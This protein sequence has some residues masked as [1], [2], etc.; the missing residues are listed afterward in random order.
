MKVLDLP[1][2]RPRIGGRQFL[3][4][5]KKVQKIIGYLFEKEEQ[6]NQV[7]WLHPVKRKLLQFKKKLY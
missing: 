7:T 3:Y 5:Q 4:T 6:V 2:S 1:W